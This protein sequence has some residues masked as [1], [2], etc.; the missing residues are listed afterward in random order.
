MVRWAG[1]TGPGTREELLEVSARRAMSLRL[2]HTRRVHQRYGAEVYR[3]MTA[4]R[5]SPI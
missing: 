4:H 2:L 1:S 3:A 5:L